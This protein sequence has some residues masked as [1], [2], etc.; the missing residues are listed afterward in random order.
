MNLNP[1][2]MTKVRSKK[3]MASANGEPCSIGL[4]SM[5]PGRRCGGANTTV[6]AHLPVPGKG[7]SS[8]VTDIATAHGCHDCHA[9]I[10]GVDR[11]GLK[12]LMDNY[13]SAAFQQM[14]NGL[15]WTQSKWID[16]GLLVVPDGRLI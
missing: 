3:I 7:M 16:Q 4:T 8:K 1:H 12:Y 15:A 9:I 11:A 14:L 10:D 5:I 6:S 13:P 2:M